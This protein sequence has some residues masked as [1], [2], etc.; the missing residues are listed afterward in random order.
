MDTVLPCA[1]LAQYQDQGTDEKAK[2]S[3]KSLAASLRVLY[4]LT[5]WLGL[6]RRDR[7]EAPR[8]GEIFSR[9]PLQGTLI[10]VAPFP[11]A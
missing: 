3:K 10:L 8:T 11:V 5:D 7:G 1:V 2:K 4:R 9:Q 6:S